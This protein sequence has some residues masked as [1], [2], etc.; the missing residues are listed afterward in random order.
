[1]KRILLITLLGIVFNSYSQQEALFTHY[2]YNT[3]AVNPAYAGSRDAL[4]MTALGRFQWV[5][6]KGAPTTQTFT[7][8]APLASN[9]FGIGVSFVN[10]NIG[11]T[12]TTS[13]YLDLAYRLKLDENS[14]LCFGLKGGMNNYAARLGSVQTQEMNDA[15]FSGTR[16][17]LLPNAGFGIYYQ[18]PRFYMGASIPKVVENTFKSKDA[19]SSV[20]LGTENRTYYLIAGTVFDLNPRVKLKPTVLGKL[21]E[22][23][24]VQGDV[25]AQ[26]YFDDLFNIGVMYRTQDAVGVIAGINISEQLLF[27]YSFDFST[28]NRTAKYNGGS[29]EILLRYDLI[30]NKEKRIKSPRYF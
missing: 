24:F 20:V 7:A 15:A 2:M 3:L 17:G 19:A 10:D 21:A 27:S 11:P 23:G 16:S 29:H 28:N 12:N 22:P 5:G 8:H 14:R 30:F 4:T 18:R 13:L 9:S 26:L 1:M 6:F 25:T